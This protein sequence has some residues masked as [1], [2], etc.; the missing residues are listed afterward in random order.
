MLTGDEA[1]RPQDGIRWLEGLCRDLGI[2]NLRSYGLTTGD[3]PVIVARTQAAS[4]T[5]A[6]PIALTDAEL[7]FVLERA[8]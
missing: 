3:F 5:K 7:W 1:A 2:A 4:S 8:F 6:N